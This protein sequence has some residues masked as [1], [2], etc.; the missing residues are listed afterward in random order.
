M[1]G[2]TLVVE[3]DSWRHHRS[4]RAFGADRAKDRAALRAGRRTAR[5]TDL[6]IV[7][8]PAAV[9]AEVLQLLVD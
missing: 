2:D 4:R 3:I 6:E 1:A 9:A 7:D 8:S 5:F